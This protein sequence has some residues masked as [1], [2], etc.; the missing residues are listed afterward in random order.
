M[1]NTV[2]TYESIIE[3]NYEELLK[4]IYVK[5]TNINNCFIFILTIINFSISLKNMKN[6]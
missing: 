3:E 5:T 2:V 4:G 6:F 1:D